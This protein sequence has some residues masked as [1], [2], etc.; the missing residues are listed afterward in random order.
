MMRATHLPFAGVSEVV[1]GSH[2][3]FELDSRWVEHCSHC[4]RVLGSVYRGLT[5]CSHFL[6]ALIVCPRPIIYIAW[7]LLTGNSWTCRWSLV[8]T[9]RAVVHLTLR[10]A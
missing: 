3:A 7:L 6:T 1:K 9:N 4:V 10:L 8:C 5:A 2:V